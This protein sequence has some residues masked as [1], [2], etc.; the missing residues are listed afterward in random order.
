[1][2][3]VLFFS[4]H[5]SCLLPFLPI[6]ESVT[7]PSSSPDT[8]VPDSLYVVL[9]VVCGFCLLMLIL[10]GAICLR[11]RTSDSCFGYADNLLSSVQLLNYQTC[12]KSDYLWFPSL[13]SVANSSLLCFK[14]IRDVDAVVHFVF[15]AWGC[16][17]IFLQ[18]CTIVWLRKLPDA[19]HKLLLL[20]LNHHCLHLRPVITA[21]GEMDNNQL[22][23]L[24]KSLL[25][26]CDS[27]LPL[28]IL[29]GMCHRLLAQIGK[30]YLTAQRASS[31]WPPLQ[32]SVCL[33]MITKL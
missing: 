23:I 5:Y 11:N 12:S 21:A 26:S 30:P 9:G 31:L 24:W 19:V 13:I 7:S 33:R 22:L 10:S 29:T 2:C 32:S 6:P 4:K 25:W 16:C 28:R 20:P 15:I 27:V 17:V 14:N 8:E 18:L 1:M 3:W